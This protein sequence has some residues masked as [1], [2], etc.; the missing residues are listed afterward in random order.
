MSSETHRFDID[1]VI[2]GNQYGDLVKL[3]QA[4]AA[5]PRFSMRAAD[6]GFPLVA[7]VHLECLCWF[8]QAI[9][10]GVWIYYE[11]TPLERQNLMLSALETFAP[12]DF[13]VHY[14]QGMRDWEDE[15]KIDAVDRWI[16]DNDERANAWLREHARE[17][18]D[19]LLAAMQ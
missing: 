13:A 11:A 4:L 19:E 5:S 10:S 18:R 1:A 3:S 14:A 7:F 15:E 16:E 12:P 17:H 9:R 2:H 8:A 6:W